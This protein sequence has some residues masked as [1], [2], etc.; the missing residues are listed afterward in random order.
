VPAVALTA[1]TRTG[2]RERALAAG[3]DS[4]LSKPIEPKL[5]FATLR[6]LA[7]RS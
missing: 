4:H 5:L 7:G 2:D 1:F 3:F 6:T